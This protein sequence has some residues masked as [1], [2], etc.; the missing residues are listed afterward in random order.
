MA[1]SFVFVGS[2]SGSF[3]TDDGRKQEYCNMYVISTL[4]EARANYF[5]SGFKAEK[6][7]CA[8]PSV[9]KELQ[10]GDEV[11]LFFDSRQRVS[12]ARTTGRIMD[13]KLTE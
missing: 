8:D 6:L 3:D 11:E 10:I 13:L 1:E 5:P 4:G 9:Y 2:A 7:K 12:Y